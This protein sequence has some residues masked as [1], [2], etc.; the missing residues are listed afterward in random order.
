LSRLERRSQ[1]DSPLLRESTP[2]ASGRVIGGRGN[3]KARMMNS[4]CAKVG[5]AQARILCS[6]ILD[7]EQ[8]TFHRQ[9]L[10]FLI[11]IETGNHEYYNLLYDIR[12]LFSFCVDRFNDH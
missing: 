9:Y 8:S 5:R 11:F 12:V 1:I 3:E 4:K 2:H 6:D 10:L 7:R